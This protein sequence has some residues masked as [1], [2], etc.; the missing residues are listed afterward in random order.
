MEQQSAEMQQFLLRSS[1]LEEF[2]LRLCET[3]LGPLYAQP[4]DWPRLLETLVQR[5][6]FALP[7][8]TNGEWLRYHH[9]FRDYLQHRVRRE[10]SEEVQPI[11]RRLAGLQEAEGQW[12]RAYQTYS[13]LHEPEA[14]AGLIERAGIPMYQ[15]AMLILDSWLKGLPPSGINSRPGLLSLRG[16]VEAAKGNVPEGLRLL[17]RAVDRFRDGSDVP[18]LALALARRG[19][20]QRLLGDY[21]RAMQD[22]REAAELTENADQ[23]QW[24]YADT[25]RGQGTCLYRQGQT[26]QAV[27]VLEQALGIYVRIK[28]AP[29]IPLLLMETAMVHA[30][31]GDYQQARGSYE[32]ALEIW[33]SFGASG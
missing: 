16:K 7:V 15:Q 12:E 31:R 27:N 2:D 4:P 9:L 25:L 19:G 11:L 32:R 18:G 26:V 8:G 24:I 17:T 14:L 23:L 29:N 10:F 28:D 20:I 33:Q 21:D 6:L 22:L 30:A 3:V 13:Q 1:L 5:N